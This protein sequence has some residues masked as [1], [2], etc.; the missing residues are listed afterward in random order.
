[1][2][3][4]VGVGKPVPEHRT[5]DHVVVHVLVEDGAYL[6]ADLAHVFAGLA[7]TARRRPPERADS[8]G[9]EPPPLWNHKGRIDYTLRPETVKR[10]TSAQ[11]TLLFGAPF[12]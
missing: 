10:H 2:A 5:P 4:A 7:K 12:S 1:G 3:V 8:A 6:F 11:R 9:L